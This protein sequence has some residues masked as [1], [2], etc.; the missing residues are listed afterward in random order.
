MSADGTHILTASV[1]NFCKI[2]DATDLTL[3]KSFN[4]ERQVNSA[5]MHPYFHHVSLV[6]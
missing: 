2:L 4:T 3:L 6:T 5:T 1:D